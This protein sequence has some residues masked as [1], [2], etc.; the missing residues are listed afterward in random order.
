MTKIHTHLRGAATVL[1][2]GALQG[3]LAVGWAQSQTSA[4]SVAVSGDQRCVVS[5]GVPDHAV[6]Q[7]PNPGNPNSLSEQSIRFCVTASPQKGATAQAVETVGIARNGIII[8]PGTAD[9]YDPSSPRGHSRDASSGWNLDGM[10]A[11]DALGLD[12]NNAHVDNRG[13]YHYHG[14]PAALITANEA[15]LMGWAADG[16]EIHY[17]GS[18]AKA[19]YVLKSGTRPT[20]P[21]GAHDGTYNE[22]FT[23]A[24]GSGNLDQCNGAT[25]QDGR[26]VYFA[27]DGYPFF[28]RCL[29]GTDVTRF[30]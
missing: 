21:G 15:T 30:R 2:L 1:G 9:Y 27:T 8:R 18:S 28:P 5:N 22:D 3:L 13:L 10:G 26:Y 24:A 14:M 16:F 4:A 6:G 17:A 11:R 23:Y 19:S 7:F 29:Y 12:D 20:A 25:L